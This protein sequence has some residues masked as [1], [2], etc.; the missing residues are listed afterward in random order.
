MKKKLENSS[1]LDSGSSSASISDGNMPMNKDMY[2]VLHAEECISGE[3]LTLAILY[4]NPEVTPADIS[5]RIFIPNAKVVIY[6]RAESS[7]TIIPSWWTRM[8]SRWWKNS[9]DCQKPPESTHSGSS[10][11]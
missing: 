7:K 4:R 6:P 9:E 2:R 1:K 5:K 11:T 8:V 3:K 10:R